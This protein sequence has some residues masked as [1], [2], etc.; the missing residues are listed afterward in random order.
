METFLE[1]NVYRKT[2]VYSSKIFSSSEPLDLIFHS[3]MNILVGCW[4]KAEPDEA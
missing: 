2:L 3:E 1:A 4:H